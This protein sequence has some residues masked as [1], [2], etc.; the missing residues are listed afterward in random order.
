MKSGTV[1]NSVCIALLAFVFYCDSVTRNSK[2]RCRAPASRATSSEFNVHAVVRLRDK[3]PHGKSIESAELFVVQKS[4]ASFKRCRPSALNS[5][6]TVSN[7]N[8]MHCGIKSSGDRWPL[9]FCDSSV[10]ICVIRGQH[11]D[12]IQL[13]PAFTHQMQQPRS[14]SN[15]K[16]AIPQRAESVTC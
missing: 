12:S 13:S 1:A 9:A 6:S 14:T 3:S 11:C 16:N 10:S 7:R 4:S 2:R 5:A 8:A 15:A